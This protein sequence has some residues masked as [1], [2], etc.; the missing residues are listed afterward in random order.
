MIFESADIS[1]IGEPPKYYLTQ[2]YLNGTFMRSPVPWPNNAKDVFV[3]STLTFNTATNTYY[4][5]IVNGK[6]G[7]D[8]YC[9]FDVESNSFNGNACVT[10]TDPYMSP[11]DIGISS[12]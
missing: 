5:F 1:L 6:T 12:N 10:L 11:L 3:I 8:Q 2:M 4:M 9:E 7:G